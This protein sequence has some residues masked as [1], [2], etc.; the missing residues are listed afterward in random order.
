MR[1]LNYEIN[2]TNGY[3]T[4]QE[5]KVSEKGKPYLTNMKTY[6]NVDSFILHMKESGVGLLQEQNLEQLKQVCE[7]AYKEYLQEISQKFI[8][9]KN[10][11]LE[12]G[13]R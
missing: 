5:H 8:K 3:Y 7:D 9:A 10:K 11:A 2:H 1:Y 12:M 6:P 4:I 13:E